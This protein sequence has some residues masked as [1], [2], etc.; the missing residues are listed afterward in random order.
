MLFFASRNLAK[1]I[2]EIFSS[3]YFDPYPNSQQKF[4]TSITFKSVI[5]SLEEALEMSDNAWNL[6]IE[7]ISL[8]T[9]W[10]Y[11]PSRGNFFN[12]TQRYTIVFLQLKG[13]SQAIFTRGRG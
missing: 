1:K 8:L 12:I 13:R 3:L 9:K 6:F 5:K 10:T 4:L 2:N 7:L 11:T